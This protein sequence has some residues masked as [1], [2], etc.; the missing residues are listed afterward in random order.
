MSIIAYDAG[1]ADGEAAER[2]RIIDWINAHRT[3]I[4]L[5]D[6]ATIYRDHFDSESL[7]KFIEGN[8]NGEV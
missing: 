8:K 4:E 5:G 6:D 2:Q 1:I 7:L 3:C